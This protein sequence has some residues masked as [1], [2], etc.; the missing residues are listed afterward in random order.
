MYM[1]DMFEYYNV[2][3]RMFIWI[4]GKAFNQ[5]EEVNSGM[6]AIQLGI[7]CIG[8]NS[9]IRNKLRSIRQMVLCE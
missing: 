2:L 5:L 4:N 1:F 7:E 9:L 3:K 8:C 6:S